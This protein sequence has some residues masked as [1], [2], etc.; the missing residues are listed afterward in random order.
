V[1]D[2]KSLVSEVMPLE[3]LNRALHLMKTGAAGMKLQ[4]QLGG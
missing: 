1:F 2:V 4:I 3:E